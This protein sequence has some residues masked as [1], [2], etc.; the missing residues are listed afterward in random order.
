MSPCAFND[1]HQQVNCEPI[2]RKPDKPGRVMR[3]NK[4]NMGNLGSVH[5]KDSIEFGVV[6]NHN[7]SR[8]TVYAITDATLLQNIHT[9][10]TS[11]YEQDLLMRFLVTS[12]LDQLMAQCF[13]GTKPLS[14][15][16]LGF[17]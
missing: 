1:F 16:K 5:M 2:F 12:T 4:T 7:E 17:C 10:L 15:P 13:F 6:A 14:A 8:A 11:E 3:G 9:L